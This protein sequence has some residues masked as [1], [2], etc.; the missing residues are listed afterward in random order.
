MTAPVDEEQR[1]AAL[2]S[3]G[4]VGAPR[5]LVLDEL[6][7]LAASVTGTRM[8]LVSLVDAERQWFAGS[9]GVQATESPR[10]V[11][12]CAHT[13]AQRG[14][15]V[16]PDATKDPRFANFANVT[17]G[18]RIRFY[19]G[20][21]L[22]DEDGQVLGA[23]CVLDD[24]PRDITDRELENLVTLAGQAAG[25][26]SA[27]RGRL[28]L[29][30][31]GDE[32]AR[33]GRREEDIVAAISHEL[34]TPVTTIQGYLEL[35]TEGE[36]AD[37]VRRIV[38]PIRRNGERLVQM[39]DHLLAGS[40]PASAPL[41]V[42]RSEIDLA[43][44]VRTAVAG[45]AALAERRRVTID[46]TGADRPVAAVAD[47]ARLGQAVTQVL[48]NAVLFS[49]TGG[50]VGVRVASG[51]VEITDDGAGIPAEELP[52]VRERFFRGRHARQQALPG[53]GLGLSIAQQVLAAHG[54]DVT[55]SS[56]GA[57]GGTHARLALSR[58]LFAA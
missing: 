28:L 32:L 2:H 31:L 4:L 27:I 6:T 22:V 42:H 7:R 10:D 17:G 56:P 30:D 40:R 46:V 45:V 49:Q 55:L 57:G 25:H 53:V 43:D 36:S 58:P 33:A 52:Y 24:Q 5:P 50:T 41:V 14:P 11:S 47:F 9:T 44:V 48:R 1:L 19:A 16:V 15:L 29:A 54:G 18:P 38:E 12:F 20:A 23:V 26:L 13:I 34:R 35:L 39:V 37:G 3:Y 21:P 8:A 51:V